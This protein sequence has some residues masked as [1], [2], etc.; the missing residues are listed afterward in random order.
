MKLYARIYG[1]NINSS[2]S[3][4]MN[5]AYGY[6]STPDATNDSAALDVSPPGT[7]TALT[8][9]NAVADALVAAVNTAKGTSFARTDVIFIGG[10]I[11]LPS[12]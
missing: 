8:F 5:A 6:A 10:A 12:I 9:T 1:S 7:I 2:S 4:T 11:A 3:V